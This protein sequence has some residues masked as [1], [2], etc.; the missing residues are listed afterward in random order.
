[1]VKKLEVKIVFIHLYISYSIQIKFSK[2]HKF[3]EEFDKK[4]FLNPPNL[5]EDSYFPD[6]FQISSR[7][8]PDTVRSLSRHL[9]DTFLTFQTPSR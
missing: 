1:M 5:Q 2:I 8:L 9:P 6:I 7:E 4:R 3:G